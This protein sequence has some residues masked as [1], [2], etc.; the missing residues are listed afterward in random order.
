[1][2][3][4]QLVAFA[5]PRGVKRASMD[6]FGSALHHAVDHG[7]HGCFVAGDRVRA[8]HNRVFFAELDPAVVARCGGGQR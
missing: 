6:D 3:L 2:K 7:C 5:V 4:S 1:M 8:Q